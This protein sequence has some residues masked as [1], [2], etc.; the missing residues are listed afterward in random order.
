M[1]FYRLMAHIMPSNIILTGRDADYFTWCLGRAGT[2]L[3]SGSLGF[4]RLINIDMVYTS[5]CSR[6]HTRGQGYEKSIR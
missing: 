3:G 2:R 4:S 5:L 1:A 6:F